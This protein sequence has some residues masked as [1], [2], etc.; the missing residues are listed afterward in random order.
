V[1]PDPDQARLGAH[2]DDAAAPAREQV[3][4]RGL[5]GE[6]QT[7]EVHRHQLV[8]VRLGD[9]ERGVV[10]AE[11]GV[12]HQDVEPAELPRDAVGARADAGDGAEIHRHG[13][14]ADLLREGAEPGL[15]ARGHD[16]PRARGRERAG[17]AGAD[18]PAGAGHQRDAAVE[19]EGDGGREGR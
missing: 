3:P 9:L 19:A 12:G 6:E 2:G 5:A 11:P 14:A 1:V 15:V 4:R 18:A 8:E 10:G 13:E 17:N 7:A 16:D